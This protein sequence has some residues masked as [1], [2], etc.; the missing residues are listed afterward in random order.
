MAATSLGGCSQ[1]VGLY[2]RIEGGAIAQS[3]QA[4]PGANLPYPN[5]ADVPPPLA[6]TPPGSQEAIAAQA[7]GGVSAPSPGALAGLALP[8]AVPPLPKVPGLALSNPIFTPAPPKPQAPT[9]AAAPP[10]APPVGIAFAPGSAL[11][12]YSQTGAIQAAAV[13][14]G[15]GRVRVC[16]FGEGS[17]ALAIARAQ[18]LADA[19]T[20]A[21][22]PGKNIDMTAFS[23]G[24]GGFVQPYGAAMAGQ[25]RA[26]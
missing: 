26:N 14:R 16:G 18:R 4:P 9:L 8:S 12:P 17:M 23:A 13:Q 21:G 11:L 5:L 25:A 10:P 3:R 1:S 24:S 20:A 22:V 15:A 7:R 6:A 19:L 2:H